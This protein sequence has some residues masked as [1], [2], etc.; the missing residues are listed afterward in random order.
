MRISR[1][2]ALT[3]ALGLPPVV[4]APAATQD[5]EALRKELEQ[6]RRQLSDVQQQYQKAIDA[7]TERLRRLEVRPEAVATP[8]AMDLLRPRAPFALYG[9]R[10][11][12]Q[13]LFDIGVAG[14]FVANFTSR[15]VERAAAG[16][17]D[18]RENRFF[19]REIE[20]SL[21]GQIDPYARGEMRIETGEEDPS[22]EMQRHLAEAHLTLLTLPWG[23]Q[24][25]MGQV[26]NR[27]GL[28]NQLHAHESPGT[29][30]RA[31][32]S[33]PRPSAR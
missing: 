4:A 26:R 14:D 20:L 6:M 1:T 16:T 9:Q 11:P 19:P 29:R 18:G 5:A 32:S 7:M 15:K 10:A 33:W 22:E 28:L 23:T 24:V 27:F 17:F 13:L 30:A 3:I 21:F 8:S 31:R 2:I 12:G 25:K